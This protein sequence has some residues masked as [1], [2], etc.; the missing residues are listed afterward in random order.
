[1]TKIISGCNYEVS[2][3]WTTPNG[4]ALITEMARVSNPKNAKNHETAPRLIQYLIKNAHW[5]PLELATA[6]LSIK[7]SRTLGRQILRHRSFSFQELSQRY[8][9]PFVLEDCGF[10]IKP[11]VARLQDTKNRQNSIPT[12]DV[13]IQDFWQSAQDRVMALSQELYT[14]ALEQGIAKEQARVL[15]P[16]GLTPT[17]IHMSGTIRS[18]VHFCQ[19]RCG[20]GTQR[21]TSMIANACRD[22]LKEHYPHVFEAARL[23]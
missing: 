17:H 10:T 14:E 1:M 4:E 9:N 15:L 2:L 18:W 6:C 13:E 23:V 8:S 5:S 11:V 3:N 20:N 19:L 16:E 7:T 21:E 12:D 22:L